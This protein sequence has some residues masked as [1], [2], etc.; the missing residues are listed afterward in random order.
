MSVADIN[1]LHT[2]SGGL[3][4]LL[5]MLY[6][7]SCDLDYASD[8]APA[9]AAANRVNSLIIL[10][11]DEAERLDVGIGECCKGKSS[12]SPEPT[13]AVTAPVVDGQPIFEPTKLSM[14]GLYS[15]YDALGTVASV[16]SGLACQPRFTE[17]GSAV[18]L[19]PAG[20]ML[21]TFCE[22]VGIARD[23]IYNEAIARTPETERDQE[24]KLFFLGNRLLDGSTEPKYAIKE[25][26]AQVAKLGKAVSK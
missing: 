12:R 20:D 13:P 1:D 21:Q 18:T 15:L 3:H 9:V 5:Y 2:Q 4:A 25:L 8:N 11:R 6:E 19:P 24:Q 22:F 16:I 10:A 7:A 26:A 23:A 14:F 17:S